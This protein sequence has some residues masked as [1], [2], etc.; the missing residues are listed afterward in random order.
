MR[1]KPERP[2]TDW[3][4]DFDHLDP[5][6]AADPFAIWD[7]LRDRCPVAHTERY[8]G[9]WLPTRYDDVRSVAYDTEHFSSRHAIVVPDPVD[10]DGAHT[11][12]SQ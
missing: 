1:K 7:D 9:V 8:G 11:F 4:T 12:D 5:A 10:R 3:A 6:W 2:V